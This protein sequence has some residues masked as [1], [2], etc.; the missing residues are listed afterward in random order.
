MKF[1][2]F[3]ESL[4]K[5]DPEFDKWFKENWITW[6]P[7]KR[8]VK[9]FLDRNLPQELK[10]EIISYPKFKAFEEVQSTRRSDEDIYSYCY[11]NNFLILTLDK[12]FWNDKRFPL[13]KSPGLILIASSPILSVNDCIR[14]LALF[15]TYFDLIGGIRRFPDFAKRMKFKVSLKGFVLKFIDYKG[16]PE[17]V[18]IEYE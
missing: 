1:N 2:E 11:R 12:D 8:K 13:V 15:L 9:I 4:R 10:N 14:S 18:N 5:E 17:I 16:K 6:T 7:P 3:L